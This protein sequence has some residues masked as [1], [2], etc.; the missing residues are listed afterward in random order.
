MGLSIAS[1]KGGILW[2]W[3]KRVHVQPLWIDQHWIHIEASF[4][5]Q[6]SVY[7]TDV[8]GPH[9]VQDHA[10]LWDFIVNTSKITSKP[11]LLLGDFNQNPKA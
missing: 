9:R 11:W 6:E 4:G 10:Q 8:Y 7:I 1:N 2:A 5:S 3:N